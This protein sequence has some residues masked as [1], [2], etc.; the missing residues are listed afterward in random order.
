MWKLS[1]KGLKLSSGA[2]NSVLLRTV[3]K[4]NGS[5][6]LYGIVWDIFRSEFCSNPL[7]RLFLSFHLETFFAAPGTLY[8]E[9]IN[10]FAYFPQTFYSL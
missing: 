1:K 2:K 6:D 5:S 8:T 4:M 9:S 7:S 10:L 3:M